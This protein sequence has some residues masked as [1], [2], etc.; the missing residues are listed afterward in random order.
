MD[1]A[2][3]R[4]LNGFK[5]AVV[6]GTPADHASWFSFEDEQVVRDRHWHPGPG[7]VV[8]DVG[9]AFGSYALPALA[10]GARVVAFSPADF[11]TEL[12]ELNLDLN[13][14]LEPRCLVA[15]VG[16]FS[17]DGWFNPDK[18]EFSE[19]R[20]GAGEHAYDLR[21]TIG[22]GPLKEQWIPVRALDSWMAEHPGVDRVDLVKLDVEGAEV[23]VLRGGATTL[24]KHRPD[25]LIECHNFIRPQLEAEVEAFMRSI[26]Y[27]PGEVH[28]HHAVSHAFYRGRA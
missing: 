6:R 15:H 1:V 19:T 4:Q 5:I 14:E 22:N 7:A 8:F 13:P 17:R 25:V 18:C 11:D 23:D 27:P 24:K 10:N 20:G 28:P 2:E 16:L 12:L 3:I 26:G 9:A 21:G